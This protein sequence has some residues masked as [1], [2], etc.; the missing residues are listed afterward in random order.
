MKHF[1][2]EGRCYRMGPMWLTCYGPAHAN[3][4]VCVIGSGGWP[5]RDAACPEEEC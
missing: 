2:L 3:T 4:G 5:N 1:W